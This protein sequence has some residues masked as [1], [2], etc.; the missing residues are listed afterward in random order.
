MNLTPDELKALAA[1]F[2]QM[3]TGFGYPKIGELLASVILAMPALA[4]GRAAAEP[5]VMAAIRLAQ[6]KGT[7]DEQSWAELLAGLKHNSLTLQEIAARD[8]ST[9]S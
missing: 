9:N 2:Q 5:F 1:M 4:E 8:A 3:G 7:P 6:T